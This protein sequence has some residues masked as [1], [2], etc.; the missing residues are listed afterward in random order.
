MCTPPWARSWK[1]RQ[2][3]LHTNWASVLMSSLGKLNCTLEIGNIGCNSWSSF[4]P[5]SHR[6]IEKQCLKPREIYRAHR[7]SKYTMSAFKEIVDLA[8]L[9]SRSP[10]SF[11]C[12]QKFLDNATSL[13]TISVLWDRPSGPPDKEWTFWQTLAATCLADTVISA[14]T[15]K[16]VGEH[17]C[18]V[19]KYTSALSLAVFG[20][21]PQSA[22]ILAKLGHAHTL[23]ADKLCCRMVWVLKDIGVDIPALGLI[24][25]AP[26]DYHGVDLLATALLGGSFK[27][28][29]INLTRGIG[30]SKPWYEG[31]AQV[32]QL[33]RDQNHTAPTEQSTPV[34]NHS[35]ENLSA[36]S[37]VGDPR[38]KVLDRAL[39][40]WM[41]YKVKLPIWI[42]REWLQRKNPADPNSEEDQFGMDLGHDAG[43]FGDLGFSE[44]LG[45]KILMAPAPYPFAETRRKE[46]EEL[47]LILLDKQRDLGDNHVETLEAMESLAW[48]HFELGDFRKNTP[49]TGPRNLQCQ[50]WR[51]LASLLGQ[52]HTATLWSMHTLGNNYRQLGQFTEAEDQY[53]IVVD[54]S[55]SIHGENHRETLRYMTSLGTT[56]LLLGQLKRAEDLLTI[57]FDKQTKILGEDHPDTLKTMGTLATT[58]NHLGQLSGSE[59]LATVALEKLQKAQGQL[60]RAEEI[61]VI[62]LEKRRKLFDGLWRNLQNYIKAWVNSRLPR[63]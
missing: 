40:L 8:T 36:H 48:L 13:D 22:W 41:I 16:I 61:L 12:K 31:F 28:G 44:A 27:L 58:Y 50:Q 39:N 6:N 10:D 9:L 34:A 47:K 62:V 21:S 4:E 14:L 25:E 1:L 23:V 5:L 53:H 30:S 46:A 3:G 55:I 35:T 15:E 54:K 49:R 24:E 63:N 59:E 57:V 37:I 45:Q 33:L 38:R 52:D 29:L 19:S 56:Y 18:G 17:D 51:N 7:I 26:V 60:E 20:R 42:L 11:N 43:V 32:L 2:T